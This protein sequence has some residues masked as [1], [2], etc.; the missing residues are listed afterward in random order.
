M[1][2]STIYVDRVAPGPGIELWSRLCSK[3]LL[4][5]SAKCYPL[6]FCAGSTAV[7]HR[8]WLY[9]FTSPL[10]RVI[11]ASDDAFI[12]SVQRILVADCNSASFALLLSI[13]AVV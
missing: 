9:S 6:L 3:F 5:P 1:V 13:R 10:P 7:W 2:A 11:S 12:S 4:D 8:P